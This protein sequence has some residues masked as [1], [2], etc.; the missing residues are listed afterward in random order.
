MSDIEEKFTEE[1][2]VCQGTGQEDTGLGTVTCDV[3]K[4]TGRTPLKEAS[5]L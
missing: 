1:C 3:G 5:T 2:F 4:G